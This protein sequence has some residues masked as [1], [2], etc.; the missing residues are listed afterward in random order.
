[1]DRYRDRSTGP[2]T[3]RAMFLYLISSVFILVIMYNFYKI[4]P[5]FEYDIREDKLTVGTM[6]RLLQRVDNAEVQD[7]LR[8]DQRADFIRFL[9]EEYEKDYVDETIRFHENLDIIGFEGGIT[10]REIMDRAR[11]YAKDELL[12][13]L[14]SNEFV[15]YARLV[16]DNH[17]SV[18]VYQDPKEDTGYASLAAYIYLLNIR[19]GSIDEADLEWLGQK[20]FENRTI[21]S[22]WVQIYNNDFLESID[23]YL[24]RFRRSH[25]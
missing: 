11:T 15:I 21:E 12:M 14:N 16:T 18:F 5:S 17:Y 6:E 3:R 25:I 20:R 4:A 8:S 23:D 1:M 19:D 10:L 9:L 24:E 13:D 7:I 2:Y 22:F